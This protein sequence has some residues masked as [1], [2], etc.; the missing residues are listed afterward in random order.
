[1]NLASKHL[2]DRFQPDKAIVVMDETSL[3]QTE[4]KDPI[5]DQVLFGSLQKGGSVRVGVVDDALAL[6]YEGRS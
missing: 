4:L 5:A 3:V 1:M 6:V 2:S